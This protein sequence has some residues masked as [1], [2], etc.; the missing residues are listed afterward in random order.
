MKL[1]EKETLARRGLDAKDKEK[2]SISQ[3]YFL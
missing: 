1:E 3:F 2:M